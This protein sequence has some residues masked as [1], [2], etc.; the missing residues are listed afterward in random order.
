MG[1]LDAFKQYLG[2]AAPGG[3]LNPEWTPE[4]VST[5]RGLKGFSEEMQAG[6]PGWA[7]FHAATVPLDIASLGGVS[8]LK[9]GVLGAIKPG[10]L[11]KARELLTA[12]SRGEK[13]APIDLATLTAKQLADMNAA[14]K[15]KGLT[16][17][18]APDAV[19]TGKHHFNSRSADGYSIDEMASQ[20]ASSLDD[21]SRVAMTAKG[22]ELRAAAPRVNEFGVPVRDAAIMME[23]RGGRPEVFSVIPRGDGLVPHGGPSGSTPLSR[24]P[25]PVSRLPIPATKGTAP[26]QTVAHP[27]TI[28][29][30][31]SL[32]RVDLSMLPWLAGGGLLGNYF[33]NQDANP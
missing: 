19:Y 4:R 27:D 1:L 2:D 12:L 28:G 13:A 6:N 33:L 10:A 25:E 3:L 26:G 8:A 22:V 20:L 17:F 32:G 18:K 5:A 30:I 24:P 16:E 21:T 23:G 15:A 7:A 14:R 9:L 11:D 31:D 29:N